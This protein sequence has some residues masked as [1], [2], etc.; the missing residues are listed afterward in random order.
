MKWRIFKWN[1]KS[2]FKVVN[3]NNWNVLKCCFSIR[4]TYVHIRFVF[5]N[6]QLIYDTNVKLN[7]H[8]NIQYICTY[9]IPNIDISLCCCCYCFSPSKIKNIISLIRL[10]TKSL[11][12]KKQQQMMMVMVMMINNTKKKKKTIHWENN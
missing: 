7:V 1:N 4:Y 2:H 10:R 8:M 6:D 9:Y 3:D 12:T 11:K 5:I